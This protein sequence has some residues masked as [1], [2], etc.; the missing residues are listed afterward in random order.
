MGLHQSSALSPFLFDL[1]MDFLTWHIQGEVLYCF[2]F[3]D[4]VVL[5]DETRSR[6]NAK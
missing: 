1:V 6:V 5:M 3:V 4:D 2:L